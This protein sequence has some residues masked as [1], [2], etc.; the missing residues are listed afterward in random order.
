MGSLERTLLCA[1]QDSLGRA[2][3][4]TV[5]GRGLQWEDAAL[6]RVLS[7]GGQATGG[8]DL[9]SLF[10]RKALHLQEERIDPKRA[11]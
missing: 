8:Q 4:E 7:V 1:F 3:A 10:W 9:C 6:C 5:W 2:P 11:N